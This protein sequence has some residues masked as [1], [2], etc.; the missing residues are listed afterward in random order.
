MKIPSHPK[1]KV[2]W[3]SL[4]VQQVKDQALSLLWLGF[5]LWPRSFCTPRVWPKKKKRSIEEVTIDLSAYE[6]TSGLNAISQVCICNLISFPPSDEYPWKGVKG[7]FLQGHS[8]LLLFWS[9]LWH[10]EV[11]WP[12]IKPSPQQQRPE[13]PQRQHR[14]LNLLCHSGNSL[15]G[16]LTFTLQEHLI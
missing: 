1:K 9:H 14:I 13:L 8:L 7:T 2:H 11:P 3:S 4:V 16:Y 15:S 6:V 12:G 10:V 5:H